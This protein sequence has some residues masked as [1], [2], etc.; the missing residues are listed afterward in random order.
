MLDSMRIAHNDSLFIDGLRF[1]IIDTVGSK[2]VAM[3][4]CFELCAI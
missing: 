2:T 4:G 1:L 3:F